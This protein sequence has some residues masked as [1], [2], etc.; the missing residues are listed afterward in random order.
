[1]HASEIE[2]ACDRVL[3]GLQAGAN[4][5]RAE[6]N[7]GYF[8]TS[9]AILG[10]AVPDIRRVLRSEAATLKREPAGTVLAVAEALIA[11][12]VHESRQAAYELLGRRKDVLASLGVRD[13]ERLGRGND[14]WA[15]VDAFATLVAGPAWRSGRVT[16]TTVKRWARS[17]ERWWRRTALVATVALNLPAAGGSGDVPRTMMAC[18]MLAADTD[19][20]VA[21]AL[22]W[23]LRTVIRH[24]AAAVADFLERHADEVRSPV[25]REVRAKLATG[26]KN[27][28]R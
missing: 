5:A 18:E 27:P 7:A 9:M 12:N 28:G 10:T 19:P 13:V 11:A 24:D 3:A 23:A 1:M 6:H 22:S 14:N 21:K 4:P 8:P 26:L 15:S 20:M 25:T 16:D 2:A 17:K